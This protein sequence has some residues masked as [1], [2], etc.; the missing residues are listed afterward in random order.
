M[1]VLLA[2]YRARSGRVEEA[3]LLLRE[4]EPGPQTYYNLA[5]THAL[6]GDRPRALKFLELELAENQFSRGSLQR[7]KEWA[8]EDPDLAALRG[9]P[10]FERL[11]AGD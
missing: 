9:D 4:I 6:L 10:G 1:K 8:R 7:Q 5:C 3:R 11:V 2:C